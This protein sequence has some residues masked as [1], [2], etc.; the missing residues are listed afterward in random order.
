MARSRCLSKAQAWTEIIA[1]E[2]IDSPQQV[3]EKSLNYG[4]GQL[5]LGV[6]TSKNANPDSLIG[7]VTETL[8]EHKIPL[9]AISFLATWEGK[10]NEPAVVVFSEAAW[11][12]YLRAFYS[13]SWSRSRVAIRA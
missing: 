13:A 6:G 11:A 3:A 1:T 2:I 8:S 10:R 7:L 9:A 12:W 5:A 4:V